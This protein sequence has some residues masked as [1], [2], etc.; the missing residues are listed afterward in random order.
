MNPDKLLKSLNPL[1]R[2]VLP[3]LK[4]YSDFNKILKKANLKDVELNRTFQWLENKGIIKVK[5]NLTELISLDN[6]GKVYAKIGLPEHRFLKTLAEGGTLTL[7]ELKEKAELS[8]EEVNVCIGTLKRKGFIHILAGMRIS[9]TE[10]GRKSLSKDTLEE[11]FLKKLPLQLDKLS[12]EEKQAF[13]ELRKRK[14]IIKVDLVKDIS[15]SLTPLGSKLAK[16]KLP[17]ETVETL[18]HEMLKKGTW[19][20]KEFRRYDVKINVPKIYPAK[21]HI[22]SQAIDYLKRVW[23]DLGF[24]EMTGPLVGTSFWNFDALFTAQDH[25]V[26]DIHDTFYI[27][28]P[29]YGSL[30]GKIA[31]LVKKTHED[32]WTTG[33]IGWQTRWDLEEARKNVLRTHNT[34]LSAKTIAS[35]KQ[36]DLPAKYFSV[37]KCFRNETLDWSHLFEFYQ[38]EGI[39]VDEDVNFKHLLGYLK[40]FLLKMGFKKVRFR[41]AYFPY[42]EPSV[43]PEVFHPVKKQWMELGGAGIF[44]PEVVKPLLGKDVPVLA[45]GLGVD[46]LI[47][48]YYNL[49][50]LRELYNNDLKQLEEMKIFNR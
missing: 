8:Y 14:Q 9:I 10:K 46:R 6:N 1:E 32:G 15:A 4:Q 47:F 11:R 16:L 50:D 44:R 30:P 42:T 38:S 28:N 26:R 22:V 25:P 45:W 27:K 49:K 23:L 33:S 19:K 29:E 24:K 20:G 40:E 12:A 7:V 35:L 21:H 13:T 17:K 3:L 31:E 36:T 2:K 48:D 37:A 43:E 34:I 41:P 5:K 18:T 39:V